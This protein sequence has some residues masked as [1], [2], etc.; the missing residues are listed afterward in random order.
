MKVKQRAFTDNA[1]SLVEEA[2]RRFDEQHP[3]L[4]RLVERFALEARARGRSRIGIAEVWERIRWHLNVDVDPKEPYA[5]N[6]SH[7][8]YYARRFQREHPELAELFEIR[9]L[10]S[11]DWTAKRTA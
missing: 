1:T 10:R 7:R 3:E 5:L 6:N 9:R 2:A 11:R 8:A 4:Y